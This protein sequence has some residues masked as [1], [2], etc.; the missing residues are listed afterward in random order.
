MENEHMP[1]GIPNVRI[2]EADG[3]VPAPEISGVPVQKMVRMTL[4]RHCRPNEGYEIVGY[5]RPEIKH[6]GPDGRAVVIQSEAFIEGEAAPPP[7]PGVTCTG[8]L[9]AGT[10]LR[11]PDDEARM[12]RKAGIADVDID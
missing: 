4:K 6:K 8:K 11:V 1:R 10:V 7:S 9:W 12:M 2:A 5:N 3:Y